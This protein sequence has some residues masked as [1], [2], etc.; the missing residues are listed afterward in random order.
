MTNNT[1]GNDDDLPILS[2]D[3]D[4]GGLPVFGSKATAAPEVKKKESAQEVFKAGLQKL[5]SFFGLLPS[6]TDGKTELK[7]LTQVKGYKKQNPFEV[8]V[9]KET[10]TKARNDISDI[11]YSE[12]DKWQD[13][14]KSIDQ[15]LKE[16][17]DANEFSSANHAINLTKQSLAPDGFEAKKNLRQG[18]WT[19][20]T[21]KLLK[22]AGD[23]YDKAVSPL[24]NIEVKT[25]LSNADPDFLRYN[26]SPEIK[27]GLIKKH[28]EENPQFKKELAAAK[29]D[30][31]DPQL[32]MAIGSAKAGQILN[33]ELQ[34][35]NV[36]TFLT[37]ENPALAPAVEQVGKDI[38]TENLGY[39]KTVVANKVSRAV[40]KSGY[41]DADRLINSYDE[42]HKEYAD[43]IAKQVL[44]PE[45]LKIWDQH[46]KDHQEEYMDAP[47]F[48]QGV[49]EGA[50]SFGKGIVNTFTQ[51][52]T[53]ISQTMKDKW[54]KESTNVSADPEGL[55]KAI[56]DVGHGTGLV[57]AI[58]A[59]GGESAILMGFFGDSLEKGKQKY[60]DS[61]VK[62]WTSAAINTAMYKALGSDIFPVGKVKQAF[63][64]AQPELDVVVNNLANGAIT[65]EAARQE[66][67]NIFKK[68]F[69]TISEGLKTNTKLSAEM[70]GISAIDK[71]LDK[72]MGA[73]ASF[74]T[75]DEELDTFKSMF[76]S[77]AFIAGLGGYGA[78]K[79][80]NRIAEEAIYEAAKNYKRY[81]SVADE[82]KV[83]DS[84]VNVEEI[85]DNLEFVR[86]LKAELDAAGIDQKNQKRY[87]YES[88]VSKVTKE[89]A[90]K[91]PD[92]NLTRK[93]T[94]GLH[95]G[96]DVMSRILSGEDVVAN[97]ERAVMPK[98]D[99]SI[100][101][102]A[103]RV[104]GE[105]LKVT[106][107]ADHPETEKLSFLKEQSIDTPNA[108]KDQL[109]GDENLTTDIIA[110]NSKSEIKDRIKYYEE[111]L[112]N[113]DYNEVDFSNIDK[114]LT[115]LEKG[116]EKAEQKPVVR[117]TAEELQ[118]AQPKINEA[119]TDNK[120]VEGSPESN[121]PAKAGET[122]EVPTPT[123][124]GGQAPPEIPTAA[125]EVI[126]GGEDLTGITH[127]QMDATARELGLEEYEQKPE[128]IEQWDAEAG[129]RLKKP[130]A[131]GKVLDKMEKGRR[132]EPVENRMLIRY[133][134]SLKAKI[135]ASP[136]PEL[137]KEFDRVKGLS[138]IAGRLAAKELV[139]RKGQ[140]PVADTLAD[141]L[142]IR[143]KDK[144]TE[145][146]EPQ[147]KEE[148]K[149]FEEKKK[150]EDDYEA[151]LKI[152]E[153][154]S[155]QAA[156]ENA[157]Q[158]LQ[159]KR[160]KSQK[161]SHTDFVAE[162][163]EILKQMKEKWSSAGKDILS[164]DLPYRKQLAAIAPQIAKLIKSHIDEGVDNLI[165]LVDKVHDYVKEISDDISKKDVLDYIVYG[166]A[167]KPKIVLSKE[168]L[169]RKD[170]VIKINKDIEEVRQNDQYENFG[171]WQKKWDQAQNILG[172]RRLVQTSLDASILLRQL[173]SLAF[174][175]RK[176][177]Q[178]YK[179]ATATVKILRSAKNYDRI[180][181]DMKN[182]QDY[183][184]SVKD[185]VRYNEPESLDSEK[186][187]EL[188]SL[189]RRSFVYRLPLIKWIAGVPL[190][191]SQKLADG[192]LNVAR[193]ELYQKYKK[194]LLADK[195]TRESDPETYKEM[196]KLVM[197]TTGSGNL[198]GMF[199][200][201]KAQKVLG[202]TLY[203]AR[204]MAANFN[205]LNPIYYAKISKKNRRL[206]Y[207]AM[208]D[209]ASYTAT[210]M[211][212]GAGL[213]AVGGQ[214]SLNP[215]E[216]D[217][218]QIRFGKKVYDITGGKAAYIRTF[219]RW[220]EAGHAR[221]FKTKHE[222]A[223]AMKF[224]TESTFRFFRNKESPNTSYLH[225]WTFGQ[226]KNSIGQDADPWEPLK[227]MPMYVDDAWKAAK[228]DGMLSLL[229]VI[230]PNL[231]GIGYGN[232]YSEPSEQPLDD[233]I[234]RNA[235]T[236]EQD[237]SL[238]KNYKDGGREITDK[239]FDT[240][241]DKRDDE[242]ERRLTILFNKG[243]Y[244]IDNG[245]T[246]MKPFDK[247]SKEE[248]I[249]ETSAIKQAATAKTKEELFGKKKESGRDKSQQ[250]RQQRQ[251]KK[252]YQ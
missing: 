78:M 84:E 118:A 89:N 49:A 238:I 139:S 245:K 102:R 150:A 124:E 192:T 152:D 220:V 157:F 146:T 188:Y 100:L 164:S 11:M 172:I 106:L 99:A 51:P 58:A 64:S 236:D 103:N 142:L 56:R 83:K 143:Q 110:T 116:L 69:D 121:E 46:I 10:D 174:N 24:R 170:R 101:D 240:Y 115:L 92:A 52:F 111:E 93:T 20:I 209:L 72:I 156:A 137:I 247:L 108:L 2:A 244:V 79:T 75:D 205:M 71:T 186:R 32:Y 163:S 31:N 105:G 207:E 149:K 77:N 120:G 81:K 80:K 91:L 114:H 7:A 130:G 219:L 181:F 180:M 231:L 15:K 68:T 98:E 154:K 30:I 135:N 42:G 35:P 63:Q 26:Y 73:D 95:R 3:D 44:N 198:L 122:A 1:Y 133:V 226:G 151:S 251:R 50:K 22:T 145:L 203:G 94:E 5:G 208:K 112:K 6:S 185:G 76:L 196:A 34:D 148:A 109:G 27:N 54:E 228:E 168:T 211:A 147:I 82:S 225:T 162:R 249:K 199:E 197:N 59:S 16:A 48:L 175:P 33:Q 40:Q 53:P 210:I 126:T 227:I 191:R 36:S 201:A 165:D 55:S 235:R 144:K 67:N 169:A 28:A 4:L 37:K 230:A 140:E 113:P 184:E 241:I 9:N 178:F 194:A 132:V 223:D 39:G 47:S 45:E 189:S 90:S 248:I 212:T 200:N 250:D 21:Q 166:D 136:T 159:K 160:E 70:A 221:A 182:E 246:T 167:E 131:I 138:N 12:D 87:L 153:E 214:I 183:A 41:N 216:S 155:I 222:A 60:P 86:D 62:A 19:G 252:L 119:T 25:D 176:W 243:A 179:A 129:E 217:F 65:R 161:K 57:A 96:E 204:L 218:L 43:L 128:T 29:I 104:A 173:G 158:K 125:K 107:N 85:T 66:T 134:A 202:S 190:S 215:D 232:Y 38:L 239:E 123:P 13:P 17:K 229:T 242:I 117:V 8:N 187:N 237:K 127:A 14:L 193:Y 74:H 88:L 224:A 171:W 195:I 233:L 206:G 61:P 177:S 97:E 18:E 23:K 234:E 213:M 141:Y